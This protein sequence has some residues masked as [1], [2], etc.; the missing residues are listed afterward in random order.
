MPDVAVASP[1][2]EVDAKL[3]GRDDALRIFGIDV[4]RARL[5][6]AGARRAAPTIALDVLRPDALFLSPAAARWLGV[7]DGRHAARAGRRCADVALRVAGELAAAA[8]QRFAVMDIAAAQAAFERL[9]L[10]VAGSTC[11]CARAS[12]S[13]AFAERLRAHAA[14][15][16]SPSLRPETTIAASASLSRSYRVNLNVLALVALFTGGLLVFST[17]AL[18][19]VRRRAQ[20]ALLRVLGVTRR[21][22]TALIVAEGALVGVAGSALGLVV[23]YA[24]AQLARALG[25]RGPRLRLFSRRRAHARTRAGCARASFFAL[26]VAAAASGSFVPAR[27]GGARATRRW[28]SRP[29]TRSGRSRACARSGSG[30]RVLGA[31]RGRDGVA[32]GRR[33]CRSSA[34]PRSRCCSSAR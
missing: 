2:V 7:D 20:F 29:A 8:Q 19:V 14:A 32:A 10:A 26:G 31:R 4:F 5:D 28:R 34:T 3:A 6:P 27:R 25:R 24:L 21:R 11:G 13:A 9:G 30:T 12:T 18:A 17:Q 23:G 1:V 22:L 15:R 16:A 33:A